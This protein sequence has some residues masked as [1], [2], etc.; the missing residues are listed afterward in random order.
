MAIEEFTT[1]PLSGAEAPSPAI[2]PIS[3]SANARCLT[4]GYRPEE[5]RLPLPGKPIV[6]KPGTGRPFES[7]PLLRLQ[8]RWLAEAGFPVGSKVRV[9]VSPKR[10]VIEPVE[11]IPERRPRLPRSIGPTDCVY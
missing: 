11:K 4:V 9:L 8:G 1:D 2:R 3:L 10:L 5:S 6:F 7:R